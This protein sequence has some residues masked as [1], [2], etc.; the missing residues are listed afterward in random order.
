MFPHPSIVVL[1]AVALASGAFAVGSWTSTA[2]YEHLRGETIEELS[3]GAI[4][5]KEDIAE[6]SKSMRTVGSQTRTLQSLAALLGEMENRTQATLSVVEPP[7]QAGPFV[8]EP[9]WTAQKSGN[10]IV[11]AFGRGTNFP[12][13]VAIH[14]DSGYVRFVHGP[15]G[16]W[17]TSIILPPALWT[18]DSRYHQGTPLL[19]VLPIVTRGQIQVSFTGSIAGVGFKGTLRIGPPAANQLIAHVEMTTSGTVALKDRAGEAFK[20]VGL[21]TMHQSPSLWDASSVIIADK[22]YPLPASG[23]IV[24]VPIPTTH[25]GVIGGT[26]TWKTN[27]PTVVVDLSGVSIPQVTGWVTQS[28]NPNDDNGMLW[29]ATSQVQP[30]WS[31]DITVTK[32][33]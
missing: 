2:Y 24:A 20:L 13:Y 31:Y 17:G 30:S 4:Q 11:L 5:M 28:S 27:A 21:S 32:A 8:G 7:T 1:K 33:P 10:Q 16:G 25:L 19:D 22:T 14:T 3:R 6:I 12:Q 18:A 23:W 15:S 9:R 29:A 26:S